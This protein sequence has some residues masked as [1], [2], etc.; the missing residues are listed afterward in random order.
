MVHMHCCHRNIAMRHIS[1]IR[2]AT[3]LVVA[4]VLVLFYAVVALQRRVPRSTKGSAVL[5]TTFLH[6]TK[7]YKHGTCTIKVCLRHNMRKHGE[8]LSN[9]P[10]HRHAHAQSSKNA[11]FHSPSSAAA[12]SC[13]LA[14]HLVTHCCVDIVWLCSAPSSCSRISRACSKNVEAS[15]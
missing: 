9:S 12:P 3:P 2:S 6:N 14:W 7:I 13:S 11:Q 15:E 5:N 8:T 4:F 10:T 1:K